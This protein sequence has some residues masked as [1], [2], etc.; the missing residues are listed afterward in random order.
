MARALSHVCWAIYLTS[1]SAQEE[2]EGVP[3]RRG[4][5]IAVLHPDTGEENV[6]RAMW[7]V[8][9]S[10][11]RHSLRGIDDWLRLADFQRE[12]STGVETIVWDQIRPHVTARRAYRA[13]L[14][15]RTDDLRGGVLVIGPFIDSSERQAIRERQA[16]AYREA[17]RR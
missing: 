9:Q 7:T 13:E 14:L 17:S 16:S 3:F 4:E 10:L 1:A 15:E 8:A 11:Y 5:I 6:K 12:C 2:W